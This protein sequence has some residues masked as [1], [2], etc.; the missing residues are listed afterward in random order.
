[1]TAPAPRPLGLIAGNGRFPLLFA[2][3]ARARGVPVAAVAIRE[4]TDPALE[5]RVDRAAWFHVGQLSAMIAFLKSAGCAEAVMAGQIHL[6][7][8]YHDFSL[9]MA[10]PLANDLLARLAD[11]RG[12]SVLAAVADVLDEQGI[13]LR[14]STLF[15][16][17]HLGPEGPIAAR[18]PT[19][20]EEADIAFGWGIAKAVAGLAFGQ[21]VVVKDRAVVAVEAIEGT[22]A[23]IRRAGALG[24]GGIVVVKVAKPN[25][26]LR[27]DVPVVGTATMHALK[28]AG[29]SV[30]AVE[31]GLTLI[32]DREEVVKLAD[33]AGIAL[34]GAAA[35]GE[36]P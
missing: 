6:S 19:P 4:E 31:A 35:P 1:V 15:L 24:R 27:F 34:V 7:L 17:D 11:H 8:L 26:D 14:P 32:L 33:E 25:Q 12:D 29:A 30:M 36:A 16:E 9:L 28:D 23:C 3:A 21:T 2:E 20:G 13:R 5:G 18:L 22:D 10:D